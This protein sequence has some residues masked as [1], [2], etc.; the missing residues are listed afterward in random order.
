MKKY[1]AIIL[2]AGIAGL[3]AARGFVLAGRKVL[4]LDKKGIKGQS[5]P[6]AAG[7]LDPLLE[8]KPDSPLFRVSREAFRRFPSL[9][10][11]LKSK[12][13]ED[14]GYLR[15]GMLYLALDQAEEKELRDRFLW[16][17]RSGI[18]IRWLDREK[19]F[20]AEPFVSRKTR[21][22]IFYPTIGRIEPRRFVKVLRK[23]LAMSGVRI[24]TLD[25]VSVLRA[26]NRVV[27][28]RSGREKFFAEA[29]INATGGWAGSS[30]RLGVS[31]PVLPARGQIVTLEASA[32]DNGFKI[33]TILH[34]LDGGYIVPWSRRE[35]LLGSTV[36][37]VG[38]K[39]VVTGK[40]IR[41]ILMKTEKLVPAL[42][43][44]KQSGSWAGLRPFSRDGLP[45]IGPAGERGLYLAAGYYR[46]GIL[47]GCY[48]GELLAR[49]ILS[50]KIPS[51]LRE[52]SPL[53]LKKSI[54][55]SVTRER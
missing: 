8:M 48:A 22:G 16:Q 3:G 52:F 39:P 37:F 32:A 10:R 44:L 45:L 15:A 7:I 51:A 54:R 41:Q 13:K 24:K 47:I 42:R 49:G 30:A 17:K 20:K 29:V 40:G 11:E 35:Y 26:G 43:R 36:E 23:Y 9:V 6:A 19:I 18:P 4:V 1:D 38:F 55:T 53:R 12:T 31:A 50:G 33:S 5:S 34:S 46:S 28:V 21:C 2:G 27:G 25:E 14:P